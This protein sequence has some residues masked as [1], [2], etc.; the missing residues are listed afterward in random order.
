MK[1]NRSI[2]MD[3]S[4]CCT[5]KRYCKFTIIENLI[6]Q[7]LRKELTEREFAHCLSFVYAHVPQKSLGT[8]KSLFL[9]L[10]RFPYS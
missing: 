1:Q 9:S 10:Y 5:M 4:A 7:D 8:D 6:D 3:A 2:M